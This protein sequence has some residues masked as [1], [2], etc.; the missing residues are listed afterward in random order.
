[1]EQFELSPILARYDTVLFDLD[2]VMSG[3]D[4]YWNCAALAVYE[5]YYGD[6]YYGSKQLTS[7]SMEADLCR[8]RKQIFCDDRM[9]RMVKDRGVNSNWDL[10]YV[11]LGGALCA[12]E[13]ADFE[14][15]LR[16]LAEI[17]GD[18][19]AFFE[20]IAEQL[21]E[22][23]SAE[24]GYFDR[25][26]PFWTAVKDCFQEWFLGCKIYEKV[27]NRPAKLDGKEGL[28]HGEEPIVDKEK[29]RTLLRLIWQSGKRVGTGTGRPLSECN[30]VLEQWGVK[31]YFTKECIISYN[32]VMQA[33]EVL[34]K[35]GIHAEFT[36][37]HPFM[38]IKGHYGGEISDLDIY[39]GNYNKADCSHTLVVGD[40]GADLFAAKSAGCDF[41]AVLT[42]V[43]GQEARAFFEKEKA[44]YI[45]NNV[46]E[47]MTEMSDVKGV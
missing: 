38:F 27:N 3:E 40:A 36:K 17:P 11:T 8:I 29:L 33:E 7:Q 30:G 37:P 25:L 13:N 47:L 39:K 41:A 43:Q 35:Q 18:T 26:G 6:T 9:I 44:D 14:Q 31:K 45:L 20:R 10:A 21:S 32:D 5:M 46:L 15:V 16:T 1:M 23:F 12:G 34:A 22:R 42:G 2:G 4:V 19:F 24:K 28:L